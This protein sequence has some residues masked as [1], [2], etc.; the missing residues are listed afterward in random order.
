MYP[1]LGSRQWQKTTGMPEKYWSCTLVMQLDGGGTGGEDYV[2]LDVFILLQI[3][4][5]KAHLF[6]C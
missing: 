6:G 2:R 4:V 5:A 3:I 1:V